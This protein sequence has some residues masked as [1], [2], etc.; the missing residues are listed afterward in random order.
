MRGQIGGRPSSPELAC[1]VSNATGS[2]TRSS[3]C[4][5]PIRRD[6]TSDNARSTWETA[7]I[8]AS[9]I[10]GVAVE[11]IDPMWLMRF[12]NP[13]RETRF[14]QH[15]AAEGV[16]FKRGAYNYASIA[17]DEEAIR[18]IEA[19]ASAAFVALRDEEQ[20]SA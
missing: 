6:S 11:G 2:E 14:L 1:A 9:G 8:E 15:A 13:S 19:A 18:E 17:H 4:T 3:L 7:A 10:E 5:R 12:D 20:G 16:L